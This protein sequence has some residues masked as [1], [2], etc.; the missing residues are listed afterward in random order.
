MQ[1]SEISKLR[2][3]KQSFY[4]CGVYTPEGRGSVY[5]E[6]RWACTQRILS[7]LSVDKDSVIFDAGAGLAAFMAQAY[8][9]TGSTVLGW[10]MNPM[11]FDQAGTLL[12]SIGVPKENL[13]CKDL[14]SL[15][16]EDL[17]GVTHV[18]S[19]NKGMP[20]E[21]VEAMADAINAAKNIGMV[22]S[23]HDIRKLGWKDF[24]LQETVHC[25][26]SGSGE[27]VSMK[28]YRRI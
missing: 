20:K 14:R 21:V 10:E 19:L 1:R 15:S 6:L 16:P 11:S 2:R 9:S 12:E 24:T 13:A 7:A 5:G 3:Q 27:G 28:V 23:Y 17:R 26:L 18:Y 8:L 22:A 25:R 4:T